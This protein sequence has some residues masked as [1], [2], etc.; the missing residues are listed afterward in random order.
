M[1]PQEAFLQP[2]HTNLNFL[3]PTL[4]TPHLK[5]LQHTLATLSLT[6]LPVL[7]IDHIA[8]PQNIQT[9]LHP[10]QHLHYQQIL[11]SN[12]LPQILYHLS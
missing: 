7:Y 9:L 12:Y 10:I 5:L 3:T 4:P 2:L 8:N 6:K 1:S 11:H